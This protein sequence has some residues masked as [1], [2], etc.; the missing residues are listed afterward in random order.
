MRILEPLDLPKD[1]LHPILINA[2]RTPEK[3]RSL[4]NPQAP[5]TIPDLSKLPSNIPATRPLECAVS[6]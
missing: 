4:R 3:I 5:S 6:T 1:F 2:E